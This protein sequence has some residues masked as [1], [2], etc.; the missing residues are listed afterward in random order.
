MESEMGQEPEQTGQAPS[1]TKHTQ[2]LSWGNGCAMCPES[3]HR[4]WMGSTS[5][6]IPKSRFW[7]PFFSVP[8]LLGFHRQF[9][10]ADGARALGTE[11]T[12]ALGG[13]LVPRI[14][15]F[16]LL[17][18]RTQAPAWVPPQGPQGHTE[19]PL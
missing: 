7:L 18:Q 13:Y 1:G 12:L 5:S 15:L 17:P 11:V 10:R 19:A 4:A 16:P 2:T 9:C 6:Q 3:A 14:F 8:I